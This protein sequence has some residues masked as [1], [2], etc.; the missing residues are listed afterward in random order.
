MVASQYVESRIVPETGVSHSFEWDENVFRYSFVTT[1]TKRGDNV[2]VTQDVSLTCDDPDALLKFPKQIYKLYSD[3]LSKQSWQQRL[4][5]HTRTPGKHVAD[6][7]VATM[8]FS[9]MIWCN[10]VGGGAD[11]QLENMGLGR[12]ASRPKAKPHTRSGCVHEKRKLV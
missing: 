12:L 6:F 2:T 1:E 7:L 5:T 10:R 3:S 4:H 8:F 11:T 9:K